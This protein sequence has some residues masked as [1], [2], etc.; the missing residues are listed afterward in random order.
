MS[1]PSSLEIAQAARL[2]P[3]AE[4]ADGARSPS[5]GGRAA[6]PVQGQDPPRGPRPAGRPAGRS[7]GRRHRD[8][9][10]ATRRGQDDDDDRPGAGPEPDRG[11]GRGHDP[12]AVPRP[13]VRHQGR[14]RRRWLQP[15]PADGGHQ[16]PL[17]GRHPCGR[18]CARPRG[19]LPRQPSDPRQ[20]A[21]DRPGHDQLAAGARR[22]RPSPAACAHRPRRGA[23]RTRD[24]VPH[25]GR[26]GGH[27]HP[28]PRERPRRPADA[29]SVER[30][31]RRT[32]AATA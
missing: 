16:P 6:R 24:R 28:G 23:R 25:H 2:R 26:V 1:I 29:R 5:R 9:P 32:S 17:H 31:S 13:G 7:R 3:V 30:S 10:D 12:A 27:G 20:R 18:R 4:L 14:R 21:R 8:H 19:G 11:A 22:E 15:G